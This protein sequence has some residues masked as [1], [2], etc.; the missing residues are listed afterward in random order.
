MQKQ[1][2]LKIVSETMDN[3]EWIVDLANKDEFIRILSLAIDKEEEKDCLE[4]SICGKKKP[5]V[6]ERADGYARD[7]GGDEDATHIACE[8]CDNENT[9]SI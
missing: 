2:I 8:K 4:C 6:Y 1:Q 7:V 5:D 3:N 9:A